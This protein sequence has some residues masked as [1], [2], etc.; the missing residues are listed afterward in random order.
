MSQSAGS[1]PA[2]WQEE[3]DDRLEP[4][5]E[6]TQYDNALKGSSVYFRAVDIQSSISHNGWPMKW[7]AAI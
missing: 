5:W 6:H 2:I 3:I 7:R 4:I 1:F